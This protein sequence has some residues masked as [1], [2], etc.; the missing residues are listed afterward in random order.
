MF[1]IYQNLL[2]KIIKSD[3]VTLCHIIKNFLQVKWFWKNCAKKKKKKR[4]KRAKISHK[5]S[6]HV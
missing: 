3:H 1:Q 5:L 2:F 4:E 6:V